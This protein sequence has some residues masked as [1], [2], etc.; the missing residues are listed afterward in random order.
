MRPVRYIA[1]ILTGIAM[2]A[3]S[4]SVYPQPEQTENARRD[5]HGLQDAA[6]PTT[7][8]VRRIDHESK[9]VTIRHG[10]IPNLDMHGMTMV[11]QVKD[12][13]MLE[14]IQVGDNIRFTAV[15]MGGT[16]FVTMIEVVK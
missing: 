2:S 10:P 1:L 15:R 9:K 13:A 8:E 7:G 3:L 6:A 12:A 5:T 11:F 16:Y 14:R 4:P